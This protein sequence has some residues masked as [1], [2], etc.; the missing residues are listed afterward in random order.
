MKSPSNTN[1]T[2]TPVIIYVLWHK[3]YAEGQIYAKEIYSTFTRDISAPLSRGI[4]IP[5]Y[6]RFEEYEDGKPKDI[7]VEL[8]QHTIVIIFINAK[9]VKSDKWKEYINNLKEKM[10]RANNTKKTHIIYPIAIKKHALNLDILN[11]QNFI[12]FYEFPESTKIKRLINCITHELCRLIYN[13]E[14]LY[15]EVKQQAINSKSN[16][17]LKIFISHV[18]QDGEDLALNIRNYINQNTSLKTFFDANDIAIGHDFEKI[19]NENITTDIV[20]LVIHSDKYTSS[21]WCKTEVITAKRKNSPIIVINIFKNGEDRSFPYMANV[22]NFR[23]NTSYDDIEDII[24]VTLK[25]TLKIKYQKMYIE[26]LLKRFNMEIDNNTVLYYPPEILSFLFI[27]NLNNGYV[28][29][30]DPPLGL[31]E[32]KIIYEFDN[33]YKFIT[34]SFLPLIK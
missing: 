5:V 27:K 33:T 13:I 2:K 6:F 34:P 3:D 25:E 1:G 7:D 14:P 22:R 10:D 17:P 23:F 29:Y 31:N 11:C 24:F 8:A 18:K 15:N 20:F 4:G 28:I 16:P 21:E 32:L 12:R 26:Y 19:I 30:P 9:I